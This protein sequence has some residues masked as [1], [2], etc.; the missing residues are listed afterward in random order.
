MAPARRSMPALTP[1]CTSGDHTRCAHRLGLMALHL[2]F[3]AEG[4]K[5]ERTTQLCRCGC[6]EACPLASASEAS[7]SETAWHE[8]C[9]CPG[10]PADWLALEERRARRKAQRADDREVLQNIRIGPGASR[11]SISADLAAVLQER[12]LVWTQAKVDLTVDALV[13]TTGSRWLVAPR[14]FR[15]FRRGLRRDL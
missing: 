14:A 3:D 9:T 7:V 6:H 12:Q 10:A 4:N 13:S 2:E 1:A 5:A 11:E 8:T 15:V